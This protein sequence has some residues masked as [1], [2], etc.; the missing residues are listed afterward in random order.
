M[1]S[2]RVFYTAKVDK[3]LSTK[4]ISRISDPMKWWQN[5]MDQFVQ[6]KP[7]VL[8]YLS[9]PPS[10]VASE[11]LSSAAGAVYADN[12]SALLPQNSE[13]LIFIMKNMNVSI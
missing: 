9:N 8:K 13:K 12:K 10:S 5:N 3:Y 4:N 11:R 1:R 6:L 7:S 2:K